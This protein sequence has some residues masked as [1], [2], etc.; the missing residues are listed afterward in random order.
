MFL[1]INS[2]K[3]LIIDIDSF[4]K[5]TDNQWRNIVGSVKCLFFSVDQL[6]LQI[7]QSNYQT[8]HTIF[9]NSNES[10]CIFNNN[11]INNFLNNLQLHAYEV[12]FVSH[13]VL[14]MK[15]A[16]LFSFGTIEIADS[17][18]IA[19]ETTGYLTDFRIEKIE[20]IGK[21]LNNDSA[22]YV[23]EIIST[24]TS[25]GSRESRDQF[26]RLI[27]TELE[28]E[29][30]KYLIV[31]GG[32]YFSI[33]DVR[34]KG[35]QF[36][37]RILEGKS[38]N[39]QAL[40]FL[41]IFNLIIEFIN[42][43]VCSIDGITRVPPRPGDPRDR[44]ENIVDQICVKTYT[45]LSKALICIKD[46]PTQKNLDLAKRM[47][48]VRNKFKVIGS[49]N[50]QHIIILDDVLTTGATTLECARMF[51]NSGAKKVTIVTLGIDQ[52]ENGRKSNKY[53]ALTCP[54]CNAEMKLRFDNTNNSAFFGCPNF[55]PSRKC[56]QTID[57]PDGIKKINELNDIKTYAFDSKANFGIY[58]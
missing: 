26:V 49:F 8:A 35:H 28:Y 51:Y 52:F 37:N 32:R 13:D 25:T 14:K 55:Y 21:I 17:D 41:K 34:S 44:F 46:Y 24:I 7:L 16:L 5:D 58:S 1:K 20:T 48:N 30:V 31:A 39:T 3:G 53:L 29:T 4:A 38:N 23:A 2:L 57:Y 11:N 12:A 19:Y 27:Q 47:A 33:P 54:K 18:L 9:I 56:T 43:E 10:I 15:E 42:S 22:G 40:I 45:N 36:S 50:N 6:R